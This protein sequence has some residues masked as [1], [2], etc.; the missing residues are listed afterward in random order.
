MVVVFIL[1]GAG[2]L[3][4][5]NDIGT[6]SGGGGGSGPVVMEVYNQSLDQQEFQRMGDRTL[7][8]ASE[9]GLASYV[10]FLMIPDVQQLQMAFRFGFNYYVSMNRN[11][12]QQDY[13][14]FVA[15]RI[16]LQRAMDEMGLYASEEEVT[17]ALKSSRRFAPGGE[18]DA[19]EYATFVE[20]RLGR[21]GMTEKD[22]R[23]VVR[24]SLCLNKL[25]EVI[26][27]GLIAPRTAVRD[28]IEAR[29][30]TVTL[31]RVV[32]NRD[33][34]VEK[35]NPTEE[36]IKAYWEA[37]KDAYK[38]E[39]KRR[40]SYLLLDLPPEEKEEDKKEEKP[41]AT[42]PTDSKD[43]PADDKAK[44]DAEKAKKEAEAKAKAEKAEKK[45][46]AAKEVT[47]EI[48]KISDIIIQRINDKLPLDLE[49]IVKDH[50][51]ELKKSELFTRTAMPKDLENLNLRGSSF[52]NR[53]LAEEIF[54]KPM[55]SDVYDRVSDPYPVGEHAWIIFRLEEV[56]EP[57][58]L[59]YA[60]A[61][62]KARAQLISENAT[63]KVKKA[64][65]EAREKISAAMKAGKGFDAAAKELNLTP[66]Q[67][68]PYSASGIPPKN[69][70]SFRQLHQVASGLNPGDISEAIH[71]NDRSLIIFVE[72]REIEDTEENKRRVDSMVDAS[73]GELMVRAYISWIN[74]QYKKAQVKGSVT[75]VK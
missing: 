43:K 54:T 53:P 31:A 18:Y 35:E 42:P 23:N 19:G 37:H 44:T 17:E 10:N 30:Q 58:L 71:E 24:E 56:V 13:N 69:E 51:R 61:R 28:Q 36:E 1:L 41:A 47:R 3:F 8:L 67:V 38:T 32:F 59:D 72:K 29:G 75:E 50:G 27:G 57:V 14:R 46:A 33:D 64:A 48:Q 5:M 45:K 6:T 68:G 7:Q 34:F 49:A 73:K 66:V 65:D 15:N 25:I 11:L 20:K 9:V 21:L 52:R 22:L 40:I 2:F 16:I 63:K 70:P 74:A 12:T 62:N 4:T 39:E 26:G 55:S 60:A